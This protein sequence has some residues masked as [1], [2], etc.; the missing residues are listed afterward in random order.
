MAGNYSVSIT[1]M[2]QPSISPVSVAAYGRD[3]V[4][5]ADYTP[6]PFYNVEDYNAWSS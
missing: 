4:T 6:A 5:W 2:G 3:P 1:D